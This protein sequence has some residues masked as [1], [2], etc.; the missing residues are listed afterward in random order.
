MGPAQRTPPTGGAYSR[1]F[2]HYQGLYFDEF[3][4]ASAWIRERASVRLPA[5]GDVTEVVVRGEFRPHPQ[6]RGIETLPPTLQISADGRPPVTVSPTNSGAWEARVAIPAAQAVTITFRLDGVAGTNALAWAG[7]VTGAQPLQRYRAQNKNRQLRVKSIETPAG[8]MIFDFSQR[9]APYS[10]AF[11]RRHAKLGMN[12]VG[13]LTAD[14]GVGES[15]RCMV[16]AADAAAI[17]N[18][19]VPL[20]LNCKNRL[21]DDTYAARLQGTNPHDVNV[22]HV[23]PPAS[24]DIDH[25]HGPTFR[26]G[27]YNIAYFAWELPDFP[28]AWMPSFDFYDEVWCPSAF[29]ASAIAL[30]S[31]LPVLTMPHAISFERPSGSTTE[32]RR[33]FGLPQ[34][35]FLFLTL[36]DLNSYAPRKN[37]Q[38]VIAAFRASGLSEHGAALVLKVQNV[39]GNEAD[40]AAL[41][42]SVRDLP[43]TVLITETLPRA[44]VYALEAACDCFVSL[45]RSEGFGLAVAECMYLGK[46]VISTDWSATAEFVSPENGCPV[47]APLVTLERNHGPYTKGSTWADPDPHHAAEHMRRL[48]ADRSF[49]AQIGAKAREAIETQFSPAAIGA[50]YRRRLECIAAF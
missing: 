1:R 14:L 16:R 20:K 49:A 5:L 19:L 34:E 6:A 41:Q 35:R 25:H 2:S 28:D 4:P 33:K 31:P 9:D 23:D 36:F 29:T 27:K 47:R 42:E 39:T 18:A 37:P 12:I 13:F 45:H 43:G 21:G 17:P 46:P 8:E 32:L 24:R 3:D 40:F 22:I 30:K 50:R 15:A 48:F 38:A 44:D 11:A 10:A 26:R 7:R